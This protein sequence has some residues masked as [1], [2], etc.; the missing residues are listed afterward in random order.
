MAFSMLPRSSINALACCGGLPDVSLVIPLSRPQSCHSSVRSARQRAITIVAT[1]V[2]KDRLLLP[3]WRPGVPD[4]A[5]S[6]PRFTSA[7][8]V[9]SA[10]LMSDHPQR[11]DRCMSTESGHERKANIGGG[12]G[13]DTDHQLRDSAIEPCTLRSGC[14]RLPTEVSLET[15]LGSP[16]NPSQRKARMQP[17]LWRGITPVAG[18][19]SPERMPPHEIAPKGHQS[20]IAVNYQW[21]ALA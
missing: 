17:S 3:Q 18:G 12:G 14:V 21:P 9:G 6:F 16:D 13:R 5:E 10:G 1:L 7:A 11:L 8:D 2:V 4:V 20:H 19:R 15:I